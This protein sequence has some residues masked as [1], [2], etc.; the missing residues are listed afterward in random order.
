MPARIVAVLHADDSNW[1]YL[2]SRAA[3]REDWGGPGECRISFPGQ[4]RVKARVA[5]IAYQGAVR[6]VA[7]IDGDS[8]ADDLRR[9]F[10]LRG[11]TALGR[12][13]ELNRIKAVLKASQRAP[14]DGQAALSALASKK[15][16]DVL[17]EH[18]PG[19]GPVL[20]ELFAIR[21][22][23]IPAERRPA[24]AQERDGI[25][26]LF[27]FT[28]FPGLMPKNNLVSDSEAAELAQRDSFLPQTQA[29]IPLEDPM[30][31]HDANTF[32]GWTPARSDK[33][34]VRSFTDGPERTLHV[35]SVNRWPIETRLG[36]DLIY[37]HV[38]R[39]S[40]VLVQYKRMIREGSAWRYRADEHFR[41]QLATMRGLDER[42]VQ[43]GPGAFRLLATPSFVKICRLEDLDID[44]LSMVSGMCM[45][46]AQVDAHLERTDGP[47]SFD[48]DTTRDYLTSTLFATLV[49]YGYLG[50]SGRA[51]DLVEREI[52]N[53]LNRTGSVLV[54]AFSDTSGRRPTWRN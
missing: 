46:R 45:P 39:H 36:P 44:S 11:L 21:T 34:G 43:A 5:L 29:G 10:S 31:E 30:I 16:V 3:S 19:L 18:Q 24:L 49:A 12:P 23:D 25:A 22:V 53:A 7:G 42:C 48:Y 1:P 40:F 20:D 2:R 51:S 41:S 15:A 6:L 26:T 33:L 38:Q 8:S 27:G 13:L 52:D 37:Y 28:G 9:T 4:S 17:I 14:V 54:G 50:T 32:L 35:M 47:T